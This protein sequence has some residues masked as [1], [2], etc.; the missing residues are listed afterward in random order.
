MFKFIGGPLSGVALG[1]HWTETYLLTVTGMMVSVILFTLLGH[2]LKHTLLS[3]FYK[4]RLL[5]TPR[6]R[7][8]VKVWRKYGML[9]VAFLTPLILTPIGGTIVASSFGES[10]FRIFLYM[11]FS[12]LVWGVIL[13]L[14][15]DKLGEKVLEFF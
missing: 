14:V 10:K 4:K 15:I 3:R 12:A 9:G 2:K 7:R 1:L 8:L 5:F 6:N 11:F 13:T